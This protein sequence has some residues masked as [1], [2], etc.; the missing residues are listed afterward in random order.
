L[1]RSRTTFG[2]VGL[3]GT[4]PT[5]AGST[6][7]PAAA[8]CCSALPAGV[9][10]AGRLIPPFSAVVATLR[11]LAGTPPLPWVAAVPARA[12]TMRA[13]P[14]AARRAGLPASSSAALF[15][16][17]IRSSLLA[18]LHTACQAAAS[19]SL[20]SSPSSLMRS[21]TPEAAARGLPGRPLSACAGATLRPPSRPLAAPPVPTL[22][23]FALGWALLPHCRPGA[24]TLDKGKGV[25]R[26]SLWPRL[27][28]QGSFAEL[29]ASRAAPFGA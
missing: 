9:A 15:R 14:A 17:R 26:R 12:A 3:P 6:P 29:S 2:L 28:S 24:G 19:S 5:P 23:V 18:M 21:S 20:S 10:T 16:A 27:C 1:S 8:G 22:G 4:A 13:T 11:P 7:L 25:I